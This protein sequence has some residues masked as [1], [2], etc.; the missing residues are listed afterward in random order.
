MMENI[1]YSRLIGNVNAPWINTAAKTYAIATKS[2]GVAHP[3]QPN[4]LAITSGSTQGINSDRTV[5]VKAPNLVDQLEAHGKT[6]KAYMQSLFAHGNTDKL[7]TS[8]GDYARKHDP[9]VSYA[10]IQ[11]NPTRMANIVDFSQFAND[12][13]N[14]TAPDF[15]W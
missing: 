3:S 12:L 14:N 5:T 11:H 4:Y 7:A 9:F 6:W 15:A 10:D 2:H 1:G 8:A 13:A